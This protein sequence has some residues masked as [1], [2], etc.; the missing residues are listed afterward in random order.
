MY[1]SSLEEDFQHTEILTLSDS[2]LKKKKKFLR[3]NPTGS[4]KLCVILRIKDIENVCSVIINFFTLLKWKPQRKW[5]WNE[6]LRL[7]NKRSCIVNLYY[8]QQL[9][10]HISPE[11]NQINFSKLHEHW[12]RKIISFVNI[13]WNW[14]AF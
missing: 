14:T 3:K 7:R 8:H 1:P 12:I 13:N 6:K 11:N 10:N 2:S 5:F 4:T 9:T